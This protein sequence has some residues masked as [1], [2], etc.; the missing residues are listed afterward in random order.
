MA[1][2]FQDISDILQRCETAE[3]RDFITSMREIISNLREEN[4][5][6][7][8]EVKALKVTLEDNTKL[9]YEDPFYWMIEGDNKDGPFCPQCFD[10]SGKKIRLQTTYKDG[11]WNC[12]NCKNN[13]GLKHAQS[14]DTLSFSD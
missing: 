1:S 8:D 13:F 6:L 12:T 3:V 11:W 5:E 4:S 9:K 14:R 2:G 7:K 10:S